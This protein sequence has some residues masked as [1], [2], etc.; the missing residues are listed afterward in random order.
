M[1]K[2]NFSELLITDMVLAKASLLKSDINVLIIDDNHLYG[3]VG[4]ALI[5]AF[6]SID[7]KSVYWC[8]TYDAINSANSVKINSC[9]CNFTEFEKNYF[10]HDGSIHF[11]S[12]LL[13]TSSPTTYVLHAASDH[14]IYAGPE[15]FINQ[16][17]YEA[18]YKVNSSTDGWLKCVGTTFYDPDLRREFDL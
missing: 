15:S 17:I 9:S 12:K 8:D 4:Q 5:S 18:D 7:A 11:R 1:Q 6:R 2:P 14:M 16:I 10:E 3:E 13:F